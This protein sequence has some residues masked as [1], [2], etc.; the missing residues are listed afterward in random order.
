MHRILQFGHD[1]A[2]LDIV[3]IDQQRLPHAQPRVAI[4]ALGKKKACAWAALHF[5]LKCRYAGRPQCPAAIARPMAAATG[6]NIFMWIFPPPFTV[7]S[8]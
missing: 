6:A 1:A 2:S 3:G 8:Y 4:I 7:K 5:S